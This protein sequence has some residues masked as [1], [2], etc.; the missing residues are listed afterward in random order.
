MEKQEEKKEEKEMD[1]RENSGD[2]G[3]EEEVDVFLQ[4]DANVLDTLSSPEGKNRENIFFQEN[5]LSNQ[6]SSPKKRRN[7]EEAEYPKKG[8]KKS[9]NTGKGLPKPNFGEEEL[10]LDTSFVHH[11]PRKAQA[12]RGTPLRVYSNLM[13]NDPNKTPTQDESDNSLEWNKSPISVKSMSK[14]KR[15]LS[16][17]N[18]LTANI[19]RNSPEERQ[20]PNESFLKELSSSDKRPRKQAPPVHFNPY[21]SNSSWMG[22]LKL[23]GQS[24]IDAKS[25]YQENFVELKKLGRGSFSCVFLCKG[26]SDGCLYAVKRS[27]DEFKGEYTKSKA[28]N[29]VYALSSLPSN[30]FLLRYFSAWEEEKRLFIQTEYCHNGSLAKMFKAGVVFSE[31][32]LIKIIRHVSKG[33]NCLHSVGLVHRDIKVSVFC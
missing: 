16:L 3:I 17:E 19:T 27:S 4:S 25:K 9:H 6:F 15:Q 33:L 10:S 8:A 28:L 12:G 18:S 30:K 13:D 22:P 26:R 31:K 2:D 21:D 5:L 14:S 32:T 29:E 20:D 11:T 24:L 23:N 1:L 7:E